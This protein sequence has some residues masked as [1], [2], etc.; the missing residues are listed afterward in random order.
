MAHFV[1]RSNTAKVAG[2]G[3]EYVTIRAKLGVGAVNRVQGA[4]MEAKRTVGKDDFEITADYGEYILVLA[5]ELIIGWHLLDDEG[6]PIPFDKGLIRDWDPD[7]PLFDAAIKRGIELNPSLSS[8][9]A[10]QADESTIS[11]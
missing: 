8:A 5:E 6:K 1:N 3:E 7:D 10:D 4:L 11:D 2:E 9:R